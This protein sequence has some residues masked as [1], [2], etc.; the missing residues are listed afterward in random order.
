L[1]Y[2]KYT[3]IAAIVNLTARNAFITNSR[4]LLTLNIGETFRVKAGHL[5]YIGRRKN[6]SLDLTGQYDRINVSTYDTYR[7]NG[8][9]KQNF[10]A[11]DAKAQ[12]T[13]RR[14]LAV[15]FGER[16]ESITFKPAVVTGLELSGNNNFFTS[17]VFLDH[18]SLDK[19]VYPTR[20]FATR[21]E[22]GFVNS[23]QP[24]FDFFKNGQRLPAD[25]FV[26]TDRAYPRLWF[27]FNS[28]SPLGLRGNLELLGQAGINFNY[29][30]NLLN[31][32]SVGGLMPLIRNQVVFAGF[33]EG[34]LYTP[35]LAT[36]A[37]AY[38]YH[39]ANNAYLRGMVNIGFNNFIS[40]SSFFNNP[41]FISG[42]ALTFGYNF[43][44]GPLEFSLA[45]SDQSRK[46]ISYVNIGIPF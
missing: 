39:I 36:M 2:N 28:F 27:R 24:G 33:Q 35:A 4:D 15:G 14:N 13:T 30:H 46:L 18:N 37:A 19:V 1:H 23:Q 8:I 3:G 38:R 16:F 17:Y 31:E 42:Y 45:Y 20:G 44:L 32:F 43:A 41:D 7:Q 6:F 26:V 21:T 25:S 10:L 5:Q 12:Y 11:L 40:A 22:M 34:S 29:G 9:Y